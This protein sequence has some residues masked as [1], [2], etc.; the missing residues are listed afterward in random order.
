MTAPAVTG[1]L[2]RDGRTVTIRCPFCSRK[3]VHG[4]AGGGG[5]RAAHCGAPEARSYELVFPS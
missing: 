3:H 1:R 4:T 5:L 2:S